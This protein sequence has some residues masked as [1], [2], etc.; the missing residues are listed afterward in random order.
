MKMKTSKGLFPFLAGWALLVGSGIPAQDLDPESD[1]L[2]QLLF[3]TYLVRRGKINTETRRAASHIVAER[4]RENGFWRQVLKELQKNREESEIACVEVLGKMLERDAAARE[5]IQRVKETGEVGQWRPSVCLGPEVI[6]ELI[7]RGKQ[8]DRFRVDHYA[9][10]LAR[11]RVPE[12]ADFF[13]WILREDPDQ[14]FMETARFFAGVGLAQ[15]GE[16]AGMDWLIAQSD[17]PNSTLS[18]ARPHGAPSLNLDTC[19][20]AA[21]QSLTGEQELRT[22]PEWEAWWKRTDRKAYLK[23][24]VDIVDP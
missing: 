3:D 23:G 9:I 11:A 22:R 13:R 7:A 1:Q 18:N 8:V 12:A 15:L 16:A 24:H 19:A 2:S 20:V 5:E 6:Q 10:A 17:N 4:G 14:N 21:L